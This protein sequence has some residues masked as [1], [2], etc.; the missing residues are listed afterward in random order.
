MIHGLIVNKFIRSFFS[1]HFE[2]YHSILRWNEKPV[3]RMKW[4]EN[5]IPNIELDDYSP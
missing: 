1:F 5:I 2:T 3:K 4:E